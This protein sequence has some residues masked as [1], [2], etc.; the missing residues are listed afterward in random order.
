M[1]FTFAP[2]DH[3]VLHGGVK[4]EHGGKRVA[5]EACGAGKA[6]LSRHE[7]KLHLCRLAVLPVFKSREEL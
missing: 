1:V 7:I 6:Q 3:F 2:D 4:L 5:D